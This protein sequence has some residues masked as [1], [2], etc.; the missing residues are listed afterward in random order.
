MKENVILFENIEWESPQ[1]GVE[2]KVY[3]TNNRKLRLLRFSDSF[4]ENEWCNK[5]HVGFVLKGEMKVDFN[6]N[7]KS[8]R[9]GDGLWIDEGEKSKHKVVMER[10]KQIE[11]ILFESV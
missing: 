11:L 2:Q 7:M 5:G 8:Y 6:G 4:V 3:A 10:G 1:E 9:E